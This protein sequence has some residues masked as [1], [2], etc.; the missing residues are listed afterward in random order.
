G[1]IPA[2]LRERLGMSDTPAQALVTTDRVRV[3]GHAANFTP[4]QARA[5]SVPRFM[6]GD[7]H[8]LVVSATERSEEFV[9]LIDLPIEAAAVVGR[10]SDAGSG[11]HLGER[12]RRLRVAFLGRLCRASMRA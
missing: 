4:E 6:D 3:H 1:G 8:I 10:A 2:T 9:V 11:L 7:P 5:D 12:G